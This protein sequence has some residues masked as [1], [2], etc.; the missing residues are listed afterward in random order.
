MN[1]ELTQEEWR[2][3]VGYEG[4]Y[5]VSNL[6]RV[7]SFW[8]RC[9]KKITATPKM[10]RCAGMPKWY[11]NVHLCNPSRDKIEQRGVH[12]LVAEAFIGSPPSE[13]HLVNHIDFDKTNNRVGNLEWTTFKGNA[14]HSIEHYTRGQK[15]HSNKLTPDQVIAIHGMNGKQR[16]IASIF[17]VS[18]SVV[19]CIKHRRIWKHL[20][21]K[22]L[23]NQLSESI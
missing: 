11:R 14:E 10:L 18:Q 6:G 21:R 20:F 12:V 3:V 1:T 22:N 9:G 8:S 23:T 13:K 17:G 5:Q 7:R 19:W 2:D 4:L 16:D 15:H